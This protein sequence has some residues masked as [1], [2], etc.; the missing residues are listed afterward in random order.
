MYGMHQNA[1]LSSKGAN[2][3]SQIYV[4]WWTRQA[5]TFTEIATI[6]DLLVADT[7]TPGWLQYRT[8]AMKNLISRMT[9]AEKARLR[10][11]SKRMAAMGLPVDIQWK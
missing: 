3:D 1:P 5:N 4:L 10:G 9:E 6:M 2:T 7:N 8:T 11:E